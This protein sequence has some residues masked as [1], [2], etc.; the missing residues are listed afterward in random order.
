[1]RPVAAGL[2]AEA[3]RVT[4]VLD[5]QP[6]RLHDHIAV[7]VGDGHLGRGNQV[8]PV[9]RGV[10]HLAFLVGQLPGGECAFGVH[11]VRRNDLL[12][13]GSD[14][15]VQEEADKRALQFS[16]LAAVHRKACASELHAEV[17]VQ[18][19]VLLAQFPVRLGVLRE[20]RLVTILHHR[21]VVLWRLPRWHFDVGC[22][23][24]QAE[25]IA[26]RRFHGVQLLLHP[27]DVGLERC[28][29]CTGC[30]G[31]GLLAALHQFT[32]GAAQFVQLALLR[33]QHGLRG[34]TRAIQLGG[35]G[36]EADGVN[37]ALVQSGHGF[38]P[39]LAEVG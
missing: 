19:A 32:D 11:H 15:A 35:L 21:D 2:A 12:V 18:D 27:L 23:G 13:A 17:H 37:V 8:Q 9:R 14:R 10:V 22:V 30:F 16:A 24:D 28:G 38:F 39:K 25:L 33:I 31:L 6:V 5:R 3:G 26:Q 1:M 29:L 7:Q 4:H 20:D 36:D 34:A